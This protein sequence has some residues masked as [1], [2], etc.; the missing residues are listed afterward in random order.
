LFVVLR[1][2][3]LFPALRGLCHTGANAKLELIHTELTQK[4]MLRAE[5]Y[6]RALRA[7]KNYKEKSVERAGR[8]ILL[9]PSNSSM[10]TFHEIILRQAL[11]GLN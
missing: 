11:R 7:S 3:L 5:V 9:L 4:P 8:I 6:T 10:E 1:F 2:G